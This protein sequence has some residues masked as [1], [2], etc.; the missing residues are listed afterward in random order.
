MGDISLVSY[1][2]NIAGVEAFCGLGD[3]PPWI[4]KLLWC[5]CS[6]TQ[7]QQYTVGVRVTSGLDYRH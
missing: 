6:Q 1:G 4:K 5:L 2:L 7:I 3:V